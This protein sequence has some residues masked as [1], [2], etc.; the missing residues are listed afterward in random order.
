MQNVP[1]KG[2]QQNG[3]HQES[4]FKDDG[5]ESRI[6]VLSLPV[7]VVQ[8]FV[9]MFQLIPFSS[10]NFQM[11]KEV[12]NLLSMHRNGPNLQAQL[13]SHLNRIA[14]PQ[15]QQHQQPTVASPTRQTPF[16][17]LPQQTRPS[18]SIHVSPT[19][20]NGPQFVNNQIDFDQNEDLFG[21]GKF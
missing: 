20:F 7:C 19:R 2:D 9:C 15:Q 14:L 18:P 12:V 1:C 11:A 3:G 16:G 10:S 5:Q 8:S 4:L 17:N 6:S 21:T 13:Q